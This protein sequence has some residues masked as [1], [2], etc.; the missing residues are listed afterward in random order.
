MSAAALHITLK[1]LLTLLRERTPR[2]TASPTGSRPLPT[3]PKDTHATPVLSS[4]PNN[5]TCAPAA[6][7][8]DH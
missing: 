8:A 6:G 4:S 2:Y 5:K 1:T 7:S 3:A